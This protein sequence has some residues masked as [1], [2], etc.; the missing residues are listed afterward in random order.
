[1]DVKRFA[2]KNN[3]VLALSAGTTTYLSCLVDNVFATSRSLNTCVALALIDLL[4]TFFRYKIKE[5][6][7]FNHSD[8]EPM[9]SCSRFIHFLALFSSASIRILKL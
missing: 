1:M 5:H 8:R 4:E 2:D 9:Y 7:V 3:V 6:T